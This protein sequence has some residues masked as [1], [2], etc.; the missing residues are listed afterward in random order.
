[1]LMAVITSPANHRHIQ[2]IQDT[3]RRLA[4][5]DGLDDKLAKSLAARG[6][7]IV[8]ISGGLHSTETVGRTLIESVYQAVSSL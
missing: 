7:A 4:L 6:K 2:K 8:C 1:M 5:A 3:A